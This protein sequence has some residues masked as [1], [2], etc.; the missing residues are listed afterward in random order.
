MI[1]NPV[2]LLS[3]KV[4]AVPTRSTATATADAAVIIRDI[5]L[6]SAGSGVGLADALVV[7]HD[8]NF[9]AKFTSESEVFRAMSSAC[10]CASSSA[11]P[12]TRAPTPRRSGPAASSATLCA[13]TPTAAR[14]AAKVTL[15]EFAKF[16]TT[17]K[18]PHQRSATTGRLSS[19]AAAHTPVSQ[20]RRLTTQW[21]PASRRRRPPHY[22]Q[23]I[24]AME[25]TVRELLAAAQ[26]ARKA[27]LDAGRGDTAFKV[28]DRAAADQGA[29]ASHARPTV[30]V[31][32][33]KPVFERAGAPS[34]PGTV[35]D[36]GQ[37]CEHEV[38]LLLNRRRV[39][40]VT[41]YLVRWRR[42]SA[43]HC[44]RR[45]WVTAATR[46]RST[47]SPSRRRSVRRRRPPPP[48][49]AAASPPLRRLYP[50]PCHLLPWWSLRLASGWLPTPANGRDFSH[51]VRYGPRSALGTVV[52]HAA[53]HGPAG[54]C[55]AR[56][57]AFR[58]ARPV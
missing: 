17:V 53:S 46:W 1:Q 42:Y 13:P 4:H 23:R 14:T 38:E 10:A 52:V 8:A 48:P 22:A 33:L 49:S 43:R 29:A 36:P 20:S 32:R 35:A 21:P 34:A 3:G 6:R 56:A 18:T 40:G 50:P 2:D 57:K 37:E 19:S 27:T 12:T 9:V 11:R 31:Y 30:N 7:D 54:S 45:G 28:G 39:R 55:Y 15:A 5:C 51:V 16:S 24:R 25:A 44:A 47:M 41:C 26:A 58:T